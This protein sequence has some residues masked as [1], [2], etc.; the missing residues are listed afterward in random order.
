MPKRYLKEF[1]WKDYAIIFFGLAIYSVGLIGFIKP[2]GIV[3]GGLT[4]IALLVEYASG[5]PLQYTYF[6]VNCALL[7]VAL[8]LLGFKFMVKTIY[9]VLVLTS[10]LTICQS[11]IT[12]PIVKNEPLLSGVIGAML[13]GT[14]IGLV[15]SSNGSTGGTDIVVALINKYKNIAFGRGMLLCDFVI[16]CSSYFLFYDYQKIVYALIVMGVMTYCIDMVINGFRQSVQIFIFSDKYDVIATAI[17]AE[18]H[19]GCTILDGTGWYT[20]KPTKVIIV[21]AKRTEAV[22]IFRLIKSID[23]RA[24]ISQSTVRGVYGEGFDQIR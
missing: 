24:F 4:G 10:L 6:L 13:C 17:N 9:G 22:G 8:K 19:R 1:Y 18:L 16:I 11:Y 7:V 15:F 12:E 21:L 23:E 2:V 14:G 20:K 5:I 3:T